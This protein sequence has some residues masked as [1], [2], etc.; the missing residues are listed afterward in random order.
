MFK[1]YLII[2]FC[3]LSISAVAQRHIIGQEATNLALKNR[4][5][6]TPAELE[7]QQQQQLLKGSVGIDNP[8]LEYEIDPY[9]PTVLGVIIPLRFPSVY[10]SRKGLQKER[11]KLSELLLR[12]NQNEINRLA[13]NTYAEVQF[14]TARAALLTQ[15][16]SLYQFI[17]NAAQ[18]SFQAGQINK[19]EELFASNEANNVSN[20]LQMVLNELAAQKK[21]LAYLTNL[22][23]EFTVDALQPFSVDSLLF[24]VSDSMPGT[25][26]QQLLQQQIIISQKQLRVEKAELLPQ[27]NTGPLFGLQNAH[28]GTKRLGLR[29]G[30]SV[31]LWFGQN[32]SRIKAAQ[33]GIQ[34]AEAQK[35]RELQNLQR[36]YQL[37]LSSVTR[38][39]KSIAY[40]SNIATKQANEIME[41]ALR[42]FEAGQVSYI[43]ALR[44][45]VTAYQTK[46]GYLE[47]IRSYNQA[48]IELKYL[49][50]NF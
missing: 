48:V 50:G 40:Y 34:L 45:I 7:L 23:E 46:A 12:L 8:E 1:C 25:I 47:T 14:L 20:E 35:N 38:A 13:Q 17:K 5:N 26:Q 22:N 24:A 27:V 21:A 42:L 16:D 29:V 28:A 3:S 32:R 2:F 39:Q 33:T 9:D 37:T 30:V 15:Q 10:L 44:N 6:T 41:T 36:D 31:P 19:L 11:I 49:T 43:E 4:I 18:R